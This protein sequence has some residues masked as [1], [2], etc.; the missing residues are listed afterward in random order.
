MAIHIQNPPEAKPE[1]ISRLVTRIEQGDIKVPVFQRRFIWKPDQVLELLDSI[2]RGYPIGSLLFW[3]SSVPL[4]TERDLGDFDLP[5]TPDKYPRNYVLDGQQRLATIYAVLRW[6]GSPEDENIYNVSFDLEN[7]EFVFTVSPSPATHVPMNVLFDTRKFLAFQSSLLHRP[8]GQALLDA[9]DVL[10][11]TFREYAIPVVTVTEATVDDVSSIF[12]RINSTG[13]KLTVYDLMVAATWSE[14]FDLREQIDT[15]LAEMKAKDFSDVSPVA[16]LQILAAH[17]GEGASRKS[18]FDMRDKDA[19][20]LT[21]AMSGVRE[22]LKRSVDF[23]V[24]EVNVKS[25]NFLPYERQLI[26]LAYVFLRKKK[27]A[28]DQLIILCKWFWKTSFS[29]RYRRGGEGVFDEDMKELILALDDP[30]KLERFGNPPPY[31]DLVHAEFRKSSALSNAFAALLACQRPRNLVNGS[32]IDTGK[33][34]SSYNRKEFH[35]IFP[36]SYLRSRGVST[37]KANSLAN[38]CMLSAEQNKLIDDTPPSKYFEDLRSSLGGEFMPVLES[39]LIPTSVV[40]FLAADDFD[41]FLSERA[42]H[43]ADIMTARI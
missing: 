18:I 1:R 19:V 10:L 21:N 6:K 8:D 31:I 12:E 24:T 40:S 28:G 38:I 17:C 25:S 37:T 32:S 27:L 34:L 11:E 23:F 33:A 43:I 5:P 35:H 42:K 13:T 41:G 20:E 2:Y 16:I 36:Q 4:A 9:S 39:N 30:K 22:A 7:R 15:A 14:A 26:A 29:Q 3:L